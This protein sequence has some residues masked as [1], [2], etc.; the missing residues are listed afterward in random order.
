MYQ[1]TIFSSGFHW[2]F[3]WIIRIQLYPS[4]CLRGRICTQGL[5]MSHTSRLTYLSCN[6]AKQTNKKTLH[7]LNTEIWVASKQTAPWQSSLSKISK[8]FLQQST[9]PSVRNGENSNP[10]A[11]NTKR[12]KV[13]VAIVN[14]AY[15]FAGQAQNLNIQYI[16]KKQRCPLSIHYPNILTTIIPLGDNRK[17]L[18][19]L[20][21]D[22]E[23]MQKL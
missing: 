3:S 8:D 6:K 5:G 13:S 22:T 21:L 10:R 2:V 17:S 20:N 7:K 1:V 16:H 23:F 15:L 11:S 12:L 18:V 9:F 4:W 19:V 14:E